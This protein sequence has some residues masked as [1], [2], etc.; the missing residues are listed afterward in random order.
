MKK[1]LNVALMFLLVT[2]LSFGVDLGQALSLSNYATKLVIPNDYSRVCEPAVGLPTSPSSSYSLCVSG[3]GQGF[4]TTVYSNTYTKMSFSLSAPVP[5]TQNWVEFAWFDKTTSNVGGYCLVYPGQTQ[6]VGNIS[7][8]SVSAGDELAITIQTTRQDSSTTG[9][10][11]FE[12]A[13]WMFQ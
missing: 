7:S 12:K 2:T 6:C 9:F 5:S 1:L 10:I 4:G 3:Q 13:E 8:G 11:T